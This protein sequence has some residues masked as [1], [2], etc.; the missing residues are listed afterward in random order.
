MKVSLPWP[1]VT[2]LGITVVGEAALLANIFPVPT[3][4]SLGPHIATVTH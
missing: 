4:G 2:Y 3:G 1:S